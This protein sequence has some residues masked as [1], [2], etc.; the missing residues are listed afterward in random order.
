MPSVSMVFSDIPFMGA[1]MFFPILFPEHLT[2]L[3]KLFPDYKKLILN[4][5]CVH[6]P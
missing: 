4:M 3:V 5:L 2:M 6:K 1:V